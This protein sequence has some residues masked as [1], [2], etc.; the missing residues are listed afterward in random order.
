M[1]SSGLILVLSVLMHFLWVGLT[2]GQ[3]LPGGGLMV[4]T[5]TTGSHSNFTAAP[6]K[7]EGNRRKKLHFPC[8]KTLWKE[9]HSF[10]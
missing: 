6:R 2:H 5:A 4:P 8:L 3:A 10:A 9:K 7:G 1:I